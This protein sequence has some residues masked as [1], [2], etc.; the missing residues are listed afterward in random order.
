MSKFIYDG[1]LNEKYVAGTILSDN[2]EANKVSVNTLDSTREDINCLKNINLTGDLNVSDEIETN[3]LIVKENTNN[4][5]KIKNN[6]IQITTN[7]GTNWTNYKT[8]E[9][10][11]KKY[12]YQG[13]E[14]GDIFGYY[15]TNTA[16]GAYSHA[17]G[18][19]TTASGYNSHA[20]GY[21]TTASGNN[22]HAEGH[23]TIASGEHSHAE[24]GRLTQ[25]YINKGSTASGIYS[26]AEGAATEASNECAHAEGWVTFATAEE[27]HAEGCYCKATGTASH[28]EG[29]G[30]RNGNNITYN[31][32]SGVASHAEGHLTN[33]SGEASH[34]EGYETIASGNQS[35][36]GGLGTYA[37]QI[38]MTAIGSFNT[39]N[40]T[41]ALFVVGNGNDNN[42]RSDA[43]V[44]YKNGNNETNGIITARYGNNNIKLDPS[45]NKIQISTNGGTNWNDY[46]IFNYQEIEGKF[47]SY[48]NEGMSSNNQITNSD[49]SRTII[50]KCYIYDNFIKC[51]VP[52]PSNLESVFLKR[53]NPQMT[54]FIDNSLLL[55][56]NIKPLLNNLSI[57]LPSCISGENA[58]KLSGLDRVITSGQ[59]SYNVRAF[60]KC[61][62]IDNYNYE[63]TYNDNDILIQFLGTHSID[64]SFIRKVGYDNNYSPSST[65]DL[66]TTNHLFI[67]QD[68]ILTEG[69]SPFTHCINHIPH[70][71]KQKV[72]SNQ[73]LTFTLFF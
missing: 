8:G 64:Q 13:Q 14:K 46:S 6:L 33:A 26:H 32:A 42:N 4:K 15:D 45:L 55:N 43:F 16:E 44:V 3:E 23:Y 41:N 28:C 18:E 69:T 60:Y 71:F 62:I 48:F 20:E 59:T 53:C 37:D 72:C 30:K 24:G 5:L 65:Q 1:T 66:G 22:S 61:N 56:L 50:C 47:L 73:F 7:G 68:E 31:T 57:S 11:G 12:I 17:E 10:V 49:A 9:G 27:A 39:Q 25:T 52:V 2:V 21:Y 36:A 63:N 40:N 51:I 35:H 54:H 38:N 70:F 67:N 19:G 34:A 29:Y 58:L